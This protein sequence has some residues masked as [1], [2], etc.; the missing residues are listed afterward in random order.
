MTWIPI[1]II[2]LKF[3]VPK[4]I[5]KYQINLPLKINDAHSLLTQQN[6]VNYIILLQIIIK[7]NIM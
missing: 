2:V 1:Q 3:Y 6:H 4:I 7:Y 5:V